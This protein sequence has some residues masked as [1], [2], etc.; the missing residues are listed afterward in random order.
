MRIARRE[1]F[2]QKLAC[3]D[4]GIGIEELEPRTFSFNNPFGACP[5]CNGIGFTEKVDENAIIK[6]EE[7]IEEG[8]FEPHFCNYA[9][10][11]VLL[12]CHQNSSRYT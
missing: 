10:H 7:S 5:V 3:P 6:E 2:Q 8:A 4:H 11:K 9:V 12:G 1:C